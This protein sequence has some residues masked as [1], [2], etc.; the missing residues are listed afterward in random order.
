[1]IDSGSL[2]A[3]LQAA[4]KDK[5]PKIVTFFPKHMMI[6]DYQ[7]DPEIRALSTPPHSLEAEQSVIGG[8]ILE[9]SA[10]DRIADV[11]SDDDFYRH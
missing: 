7:D 3:Y 1:M 11:V 9:N 8:L 4:W 6:T 2:A 10:W 5:V